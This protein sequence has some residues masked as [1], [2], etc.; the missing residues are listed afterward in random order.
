[1]QVFMVLFKYDV[2]RKTNFKILKLWNVSPLCR[3]LIYIPGYTIPFRSYRL[4]HF[5]TAY[6]DFGFEHNGKDILR[7]LD[8][9]KTEM[10][11]WFSK[12][13]R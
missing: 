10:Q 4:Y 1:M 11:I 5:V 2:D 8:D 7:V 3:A 12:T 13:N 6:L 9:T